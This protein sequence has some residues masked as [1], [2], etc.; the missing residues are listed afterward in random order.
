MTGTANRIQVPALVTAISK[1][2]GMSLEQKETLLDEIYK[3]QPNM[4]GSVVVQNR[5]GVSFEKM[6]FLLEILMVCFQAMKESQLRWP[7]ITIGDQDRQMTL[8]VASI[9]FGE[10]LSESLHGRLMKQY[11][12]NHPEQ[13]LLAFVQ[14]ET[15]AW[16]RRVVSE[17]SDKHVMLAAAT[18]VN[19]IA[20]VPMPTSGKVS[21]KQNKPR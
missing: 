18:L 11:I 12:D 13:Y 7:L 8:Y 16:M 20:F 17:E 1:V 19:C 2:R 9:K 15:A 21:G 4:L 5:M 14:S 10:D 6:E 3:A